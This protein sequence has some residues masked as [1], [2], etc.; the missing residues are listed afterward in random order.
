MVKI[1]DGK[2]ISETIKDKIVQEIYELKGQ[3]PNLAIVLLGEREDS[4]LYVD[5]KRKQAKMVG[6]DTH[7]YHLT[8]STKEKELLEVI[9]FLNQDEL[10][11]GILVQLPLPKHLDADK[12][13]NS[14][15]YRKDVD[16]FHKESLDKIDSGGVFLS[17]VFASVLRILQEINYKLE[18]KQVA[19]IYNSLIFGSGLVK[20]VK[21]RKGKSILIQK[22]EI[23]LKKDQISQ[24]DVV[25]TALGVPKFLD[26]TYIKQGAVVID[27]G[28][29][30][31]NG[32]VVGD[33]DSDSVK[34]L[35]S[36]ITP[37]PGGI[38][39]MTIAMLFKNTLEAFKNKIK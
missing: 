10:I 23:E 5:L 4:K 34:E 3:R 12:I 7:F 32:K 20:L 33:V 31:F 29:S 21:N 1:I 17:P 37:V 14:L 11:D 18:D 38:G 24:S 2:K 39:P 9:D 26:K 22:D 8:E 35:A 16:G 13:I 30:K 27:V 19:I 6:I 25:I 36:Y 15:D 28:I